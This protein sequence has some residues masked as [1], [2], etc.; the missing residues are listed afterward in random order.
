MKEP[1]YL[2]RT[3]ESEMGELSNKELIERLTACQNHISEL[4][5]L[6]EIEIT[7]EEIEKMRSKRAKALYRAYL[8]DNTDDSRENIKKQALWESYEYRIGL[9]DM[10]DQ[11]IDKH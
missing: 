1:Y 2:G 5:R 4:E 6:P 3:P 8:V 10:R 7:D 11:L 9:T